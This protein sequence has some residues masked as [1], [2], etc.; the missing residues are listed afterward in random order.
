MSDG[1]VIL[2]TIP[3]KSVSLPENFLPSQPAKFY[4]IKNTV[5][6]FAGR[7]SNAVFLFFVD[8]GRFSPTRSSTFWSVFASHYHC[9]RGQLFFQFRI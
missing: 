4:V 5:Y 8:P 9:D 3:F 2:G 1:V 7:A 6:I